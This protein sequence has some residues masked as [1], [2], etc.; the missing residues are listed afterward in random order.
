MSPDRLKLKV[1]CALPIPGQMVGKCLRGFID[2]RNYEVV[3]ELLRF[4]YAYSTLSPRDYPS[5]I[6]GLCEANMTPEV[7]EM[8]WKYRRNCDEG[9][10]L[11]SIMMQVPD[12]KYARLYLPCLIR[13]GLSATWDPCV[14]CCETP[15]FAAKLLYT[16]GQFSLLKQREV[17]VDL[18]R[19]AI[20]KHN[21]PLVEFI[22]AFQR[23]NY[24]AYDLFGVRFFNWLAGV[25]KRK[26]TSQ[27]VRNLIVALYFDLRHRGISSS[28]MRALEE[29]IPF[30]C[31]DELYDDDIALASF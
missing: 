6:L 11:L 5:M 17:S 13:E 21:L 24:K 15:E 9:K 29:H 26:N 14:K 31:E 28:V 18:L 3:N 22:D 27:D 2:N 8:L 16:A 1:E 4:I 25:M 10:L 30:E 20:Y 19:C 12:E 7:A 23:K